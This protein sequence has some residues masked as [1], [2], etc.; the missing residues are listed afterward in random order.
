MP[1]VTI[2]GAREGGFPT[3]AEGAP[4]TLAQINKLAEIYDAVK[5]KPGIKTPMAI[6]WTQWKKIYKKVGNKWIKRE[7]KKELSEYKKRTFQT[8]VTKAE[9]KSGDWIVWGYASTFNVDSGNDQITKEALLGA[10]DDFV[11]YSTVLFNHDSNRPI[12]KVIDTEVDDIGLLIKVSLSKTEKELWT[13]IK[14]GII[15]KFSINGRVIEEE[16]IDDGNIYQINKIKFFEVSLVSV[17]A[18]KYA[19]AVDSYTSK[20]QDSNNNMNTDKILEELKGITKS[21]SAKEIKENLHHLVDAI[22]KSTDIVDKGSV[23]FAPTSEADVNISWDGSMAEGALAKYASSDGSGDKDKINWNKYRKGFA[24]YDATDKENF[25]SYKLPHHTIKNGK[26][27]VVWR[28]VAAAMAALLGARGGIKIP[29]NDKDAVYNH[30]AKHYKQFDKKEPKKSV[31]YELLEDEDNTIITNLQ[32]LAG[33]LS[34]EEKEAIENAIRFMQDKNEETLSEE[35]QQ[36]Y[37]F[38]EISED[39]PIYQLNSFTK[40]ELEEGSSFR[41]QVLKYGKWYHWDAE[42]GVLEITKDLVKKI[43]DNFKQKIIENVSVPLT[44]TNDPSKNTGN[45]VDLIQTEKGL[46]AIIE[47][48]DK[49]IADKIKEGLIKCVSASIDPNYLVKTSNKFVGPVMLHTALVQEPYIKG[50]QEFI[51]LS[52]DFS[53]RPVLQFEDTALSIR[54]E[55]K[56][57]KDKLI[58]LSMEIKKENEASSEDE[59]KDTKVIDDEK[60]ADD[61]KGTEDEKKEEEVSDEKISESLDTSLNEYVKKMVDD[62]KTEEEAKETSK[63][64]NKT[65]YSDC[66]KKQLK[67]KKK[68]TEAV[69]ICKAEMEKQLSESSTEDKKS[70]EDKDVK[71]DA[72]VDLAEA[73]NTYEE[74]LKQG[75]IIPAQKEAFIKLFATK[76]ALELSDGKKVDLHEVLKSF[77]E[78]QPKIVDFEEKG[79]NVNADKDTEKKTSDDMPEE[80]KSF[81]AN[82]LGLS[83]EDAKESW[84]HAQELKKEED[85]MKET[86]F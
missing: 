24:W 18:N 40:I 84:K 78:A 79:T 32:I 35:V 7:K 73:E 81:F 61:N 77:L 5:N 55:I 23:A 47:I 59:K 50:M 54:Q 51:P 66:M 25:G 4:L 31:A 64:V 86:I 11:E 22:D 9:E 6:A 56:L 49:S 30:L 80:A 3:S 8:E 34:G 74:Y 28:G 42:K 21:R 29:E 17:P 20:S 63:K 53:G 2:P 67:A 19:E 83:D 85:D 57:L 46:D 45:V 75:K 26:L 43:V 70:E 68:F 72:K 69:K 76:K 52:E 36:V 13:K 27:V 48:K 12:G 38:D 37:N 82:K 60:K 16:S 41:K 1:Y 62:G 39:R 33:K 44:H 10:K 65:K 15:S 14:E 71:A 58:E